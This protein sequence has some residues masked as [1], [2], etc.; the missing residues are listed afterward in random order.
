M[1]REVSALKDENMTFGLICIDFGR[2]DGLIPQE[3]LAERK[4][5]LN[6]IT[7]WLRCSDYAG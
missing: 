7:R 3:W 2:W 5:G 4:P 1:I 6:L